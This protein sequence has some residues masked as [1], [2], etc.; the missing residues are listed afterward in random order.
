MATDKILDELKR[1]VFLIEVA[2][3]VTEAPPE[4]AA[5]RAALE[6]RKRNLDEQIKQ[7]EKR[8]DED[9]RRA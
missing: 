1:R 7:R 5:K 2:I 3:A 8:H 9:F 6:K 4:D